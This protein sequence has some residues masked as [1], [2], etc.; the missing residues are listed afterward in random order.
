MT[1]SEQPRND[2]ILLCPHCDRPVDK[3]RVVQRLL[4]LYDRYN[5]ETKEDLQELARLQDFPV[6]TVFPCVCDLSI[7]CY[8]HE[9]G[10]MTCEEL[11]RVRS[12]PEPT[13]PY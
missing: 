8:L 5:P 6:Y 2:D 12:R 10:S 1:A 11:D 3:S 13:A 9:D 7:V 4:N